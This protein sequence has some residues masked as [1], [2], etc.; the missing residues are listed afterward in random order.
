MPQD[1]GAGKDETAELA[2]AAQRL[3][4]DAKSEPVP[5]TLIELARQLEAAIAKKRED[6]VKK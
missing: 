3:L 2:A 5:E 1:S 6:A 4:E